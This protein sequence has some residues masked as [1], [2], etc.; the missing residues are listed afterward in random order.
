[1][2][3]DGSRF[4]LGDHLGQLHLL[5]LAQEGGHVTGLKLEPLGTTTAASTI[6]CDPRPWT[7]AL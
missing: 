2:D 3:T 1:M 4:L 7:L 6:T 5:V